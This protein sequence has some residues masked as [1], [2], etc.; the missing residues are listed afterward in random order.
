MLVQVVLLD[1]SG[2]QPCVQARPKQLRLRR[3]TAVE[4]E[5]SSGT[6][7][8]CRPSPS[9][10]SQEGQNQQLYKYIVIYI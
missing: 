2:R 5:D 3:P 10:L 1:G 4:L 8:G 7:Q 6:V 9:D